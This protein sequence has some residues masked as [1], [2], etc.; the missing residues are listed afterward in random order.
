MPDPSTTPP[1]LVTIRD[2]AVIA[3]G[4]T[5]NA[6]DTDDY[7]KQDWKW[8]EAVLTGASAVNNKSGVATQAQQ[9]QAM[10]SPQSLRDAATIFNNT[11]S[12]MRGV[13]QNLVAQAKGLA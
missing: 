13:A 10:V 12:V 1:P 8:I 3:S 7:T 11:Q 9:G 6:T 4:E 2:G 5:G